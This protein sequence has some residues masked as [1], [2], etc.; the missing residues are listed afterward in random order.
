MERHR[1]GKRSYAAAERPLMRLPLVLL[2]LLLMLSGCDDFSFYKALG[3]VK[4]EPLSISPASL[5]LYVG[6]SSPYVFTASGG[7]PPYTF[8][9]ISGGGS[10][11]ALTA[12]YTAGPSPDA[13]TIQVTDNVGASREATVEI[14][15]AV[16]P[17]VLSPAAVSML[18]GTSVSFT[19][20]GGSDPLSFQITSGAGLGSVSPTGP[21]EAQFDAGSTTG[22]VV[23]EVTDAF[24]QTDSSDITIVPYSSSV[25]YTLPS[26]YASWPETG[27][28]AG[29]VCYGMFRIENSGSADGAQPVE[30]IVYASTDTTPGGGDAVIDS[31]SAGYLG[32]GD[33][34]DIG[35]NGFWP[36]TPAGY[37][38]IVVV[39]SADEGVPG[40]NTL[41][42]PIS[43][44]LTM[45]TVDYR[46][47]PDVW[48]GPGA[49]LSACNGSFIL[50]N[51]G[52]LD[53]GP[54]VDWIVYASVDAAVGGGDHI[55]ASGGGITRTAGQSAPVAFAG[56][57]PAQPGDY[58]LIVVASADDDANPAN[59][60]LVSA[61]PIQVFD[62]Y[63][64]IEGNGTWD[65]LVLD[66]GQLAAPLANDTGFVLT[67]GATYRFTGFMETDG[68]DIFMF[69]T[70]TAVSMLVAVTWIGTDTIDAYLHDGTPGLELEGG[71][72]IDG[73]ESFPFDIL[74]QGYAGADLFLTIGNSTLPP[75]FWN[76][77]PGADRPYLVTVTCF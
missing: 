22:A 55:V 47:Q 72:V 52:A 27:Q 37:Y 63:A 61:A 17:I 48:P 58:R 67:P 23:I 45:D 25:D 7:V 33:W 51:I 42:S 30:F 15:A 24:M 28:Q 18:P 36:S 20:I 21:R 39:T 16:D 71:Q 8:S 77:S 62:E 50:E 43:Y 76:D 5:K 10:F 13:A 74:G 70:G 60:T 3:E 34:V 4:E 12:T 32:A 9:L 40:N 31:N 35:Y 6:D 69:N 2:V 1:A 19:V 57:W 59:N 38:L 56:T 75:V 29:G 46:M 64:E 26:V 41:V 44:P 73:Y 66:F 65:P 54:P 68:A 53:G 11:D 14:T 49:V